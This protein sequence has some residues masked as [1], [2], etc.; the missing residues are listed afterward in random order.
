[1]P[2]ESPVPAHRALRPTRIH[3]DPI[4]LRRIDQPGLAALERTLHP[5]LH[6]VRP[7]VRAMLSSSP[8]TTR[9]LHVGTPEVW[10]ATRADDP[11]VIGIGWLAGA[12]TEVIAAPGHAH[13]AATLQLVDTLLAVARARRLATLT[14]RLAGPF[15][16]TTSVEGGRA[17]VLAERNGALLLQLDLPQPPEPDHVAS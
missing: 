11:T 17:R 12:A 14:A 6:G 16:A 1:V 3:V 8:L 13:D 7:F 10:A 9:P 4:R 15:H 2:H 5:A